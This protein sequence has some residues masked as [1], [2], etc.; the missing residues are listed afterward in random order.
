MHMYNKEWCIKKPAD[1]AIHDYI[2]TTF[3]EQVDN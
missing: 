3:P 2:W 1:Q